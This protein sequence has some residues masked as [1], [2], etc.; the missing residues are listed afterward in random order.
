MHIILL[1]GKLFMIKKRNYYIFEQFLFSIDIMPMQ[2]EQNA[3]SIVNKQKTYAQGRAGTLEATSNLGIYADSKI[4]VSGQQKSYDRKSKIFLKSTLST[5][6][7]G[8]K[9][10][11]CSSF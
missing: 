6:G 2:Q 11:V 1:T 8:T 7:C 3:I 4:V 5:M 10:L 9:K